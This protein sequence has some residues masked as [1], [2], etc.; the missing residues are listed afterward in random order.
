M[1]AHRCIRTRFAS[2][3]LTDWHFERAGEELS[4]DPPGRLVVSTASVQAAIDL[5]I[6]GHGL[7]QIFRNWVQ[8][9]LDSGALVPVLADWWP[10]FE[11]P[12]LYFSSRFMPAPLRAFVDLVS[13]SRAAAGPVPL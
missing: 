8:P 5:A 4:L 12:Q 9:H 2:G 7:I 1:L 6:A 13:A 11:G 3:A 10:E